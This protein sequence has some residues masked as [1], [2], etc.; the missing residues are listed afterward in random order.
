MCVW[1][2]DL[3]RSRQRMFALFP[4]PI[5]ASITF[6]IDLQ[7]PFYFCFL[8]LFCLNVLFFFLLYFFFYFHSSLRHLQYW[9]G[10]YF[11]IDWIS[12]KLGSLHHSSR[13]VGLHSARSSQELWSKQI[14]SPSSWFNFCFGCDVGGSDFW[15]PWYWS[16]PPPSPPPPQSNLVRMSWITLVARSVAVMSSS[17]REA[18]LSHSADI[19]WFYIFLI[20]CISNL[21]LRFAFLFWFSFKDCLLTCSPTRPVCCSIRQVRCLHLW[22]GRR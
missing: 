8:F 15:D 21:L 3:S 5:Q 6:D 19:T 2:C 12:I 10:K 13:Q 17:L 1:L 16:S 18:A 7:N 14:I 11:F 4:L 22:I 9:F 20:S